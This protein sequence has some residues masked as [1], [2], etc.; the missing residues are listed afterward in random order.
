MFNDNLVQRDGYAWGN[1]VGDRRY[2]N[3]ENESYRNIKNHY[4]KPKKDSKFGSSKSKV[5]T[6]YNVCFLRLS[7]FHIKQ[8]NI[9]HKMFM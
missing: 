2:D 1:H 8:P 7:N 9:Y 5:S 4:K 6:P 3:N